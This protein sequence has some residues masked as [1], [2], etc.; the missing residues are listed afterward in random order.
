MTNFKTEQEKFWATD[1]GNEYITRNQGSHIIATNLAL[2]SKILASTK[3][4]ESIREFGA[5]IGL[6]LLAI[7]SL[8]P[9]VKLEGIE[10]NEQAVNELKKLNEI[11]V[12]HQSIL[13]FNS[14]KPVNFVLIKGVLIHI[15]PDFLPDVYQ[16][17]YDSTDRYICICEYYNP[18]PVELNYRGHSGKLF[19]RDFAGEMLDKFSD[20]RLL[21]Y[22][23]TYH[24]D[25]NFPQ[26]DINWFLL[27]K[28]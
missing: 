24:R 27:E 19:K 3:N 7:K 16:S 21:D 17:L 12:Y 26:D 14:I 8:L 11:K 20:L 13:D 5:N 4:I 23:F 2:F 6:N 9:K 28:N 10:I 1:F 18:S 22:G 25:S 15:N